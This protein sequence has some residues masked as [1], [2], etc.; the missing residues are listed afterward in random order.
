MSPAIP[1]IR[2]MFDMFEP[3]AFPIARS[4]L[5]LRTARM[6]TRSSGAEVPKA[7]I[8]SPITSVDM[9]NFLA[10]EDAPSTRRSAPLSNAINPTTKSAYGMKGSNMGNRGEVL[11]EWLL[12]FYHFFTFFGICVVGLF[13]P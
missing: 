2:R 13:L 9:L 12:G 3:I 7:I 6:L 1:R 11:K 8:V 4:G 5:P 10:I